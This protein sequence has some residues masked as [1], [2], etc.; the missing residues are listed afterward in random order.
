MAERG[1]AEQRVDGREAPVA[2]A[3]R[4]V[5]VVFEVSKNAAISGAS[6][7]AMSNADGGL[8]VLAVA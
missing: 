3:D 2:R 8:P 1:V 7:S 6:R 5:P 4:V